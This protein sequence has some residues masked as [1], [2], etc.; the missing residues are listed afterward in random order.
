[1]DTLGQ[2]KLLSFSGLHS[3]HLCGDGVTASTHGVVFNIFP[4]DY[5]LLV[6][7][8]VTSTG[9]GPGS[10][11]ANNTK[12]R[13]EFAFGAREGRGNTHQQIHL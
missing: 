1:M 3:P 7:Y 2:I 10:P 6:T 9:L 4:F 5:N 8:H 12:A 13:V 11:T